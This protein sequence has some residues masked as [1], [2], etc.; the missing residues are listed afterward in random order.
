MTE[1][2]IQNKA[3]EYSTSKHGYRNETHEAYLNDKQVY[4][5]GYLQALKDLSEQFK[6]ITKIYADI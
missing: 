4:L 5:D 2:E 3:E 1:Y 6:N